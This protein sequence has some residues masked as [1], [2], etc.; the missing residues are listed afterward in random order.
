MCSIKL[1]GQSAHLFESMHRLTK[2]ESRQGGFEVRIESEWGRKEDLQLLHQKLLPVFERLD[3]VN[4][5]RAGRSTKHLQRLLHSL[6]SRMLI[7]F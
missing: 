7:D 2:S 5:E 6:K 1:Q 3:S 4:Q